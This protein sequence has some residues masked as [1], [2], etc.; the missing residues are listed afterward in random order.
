MPILKGKG[1]VK[2]KIKKEDIVIGGYYG[3]GSIGDEAI[4]DSIEAP[5]TLEEIGL[6]SATLAMT[7]K[8]TKVIRDKYVLPRLLWDIG[9]LDSLCEKVFG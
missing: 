6:D 1:S 9:E 8:S 4:L 7:C 2:M 5:K 3:F